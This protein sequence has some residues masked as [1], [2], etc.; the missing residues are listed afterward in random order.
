MLNI[1]LN[2]QGLSINGQIWNFPIPIKAFCS[3]LG[4]YRKVTTAYQHNYLWDNEGL[5]AYSKNDD[6]IEDIT[7]LLNPEKY[8]HQPKSAF[9]G[10]VSFYKKALI[11]YYKAHPEK[12]VALYI[13]DDKHSLIAQNISVSLYLKDPYSF[14]CFKS[15]QAP[16]IPLPLKLDTSFEYYSSLWVNWLY[17]IQSYVPSYNRFYNLTYGIQQHDIDDQQSL[18][19]GKLPASLINFYKVHNVYWDAVTS[20]FQFH[21]NG[22]GYDLLPFSKLHNEW[23]NIMDLHEEFDSE[24]YSSCLEDYDVK[25]KAIGYSNPSW[26]PFAEGRNG[27]YLVIDLD[28]NETGKVG[29]IIELQNEAWSRIVFFDSLE[30][31]LESTIQQ[32]NTGN[33]TRYEWIQ[34]KK[35]DD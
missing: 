1:D 2:D 23:E 3:S 6:F 9:A 19:E 11:D 29:Q 26:I 4:T 5:V 30:Q 8:D 7:L 22:W 31:L 21:V 32:L 33:D 25:V 13:G 10:Q 18:F 15:Y 28:P 27:D 35:D 24:E 12:R 14:I 17:A 16:T 34:S 20:V